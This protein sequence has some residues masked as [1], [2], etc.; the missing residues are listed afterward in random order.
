MGAKR[1][2]IIARSSRNDESTGWQTVASEQHFRTLEEAHAFI[3]TQR[4]AFPLHKTTFIVSYE[5]GKTLPTDATE[6]WVQKC[7]QGVR[8]E[9]GVQK[10]SVIDAA[11]V[12]MRSVITLPFSPYQG[13]RVLV[14]GIQPEQ[15][16]LRPL[17]PRLLQHRNITPE[18]VTLVSATTA[19]L[20]YIRQ[21]YGCVDPVGLPKLCQM[22]RL[23]VVGRGTLRTQGQN[24]SIATVSC[25]SDIIEVAQKIHVEAVR[26]P[27]PA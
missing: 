18:E 14:V 2:P 23:I 17:I 21:L 26:V 9:R 11:L 22:P 20:P 4:L 7:L 27:T 6:L 13:N 3:R 1:L 16:R 8:K 5:S 10:L 24:Q 25:P 12:L 15:A 19:G